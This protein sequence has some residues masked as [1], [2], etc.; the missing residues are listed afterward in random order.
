M[1]TSKAIGGMFGGSIGANFAPAVG[2]I[3]LYAIE[4]G[5]GDLPPNIDVAVTVVIVSLVGGALA[6][7]GAWIAAPNA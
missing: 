1:N 4:R 6:Y 2:D 5:V 7:A 3:G